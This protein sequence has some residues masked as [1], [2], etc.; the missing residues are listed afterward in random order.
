MF[1]AVA[2]FVIA[3]LMPSFGRWSAPKLARV[4]KVA[5]RPDRRQAQASSPS[6]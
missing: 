4:R 5:V 2:A 1:S 6:T 3:C